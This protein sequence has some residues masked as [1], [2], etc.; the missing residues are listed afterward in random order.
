MDGFFGKRDGQAKLP[1]DGEY[2]QGSDAPLT[3]NYEETLKTINT[4]ESRAVSSCLLCGA[5]G[6]LLYGD[7][8]DYLFGAPGLWNLRKCSDPECGLIWIDPM[9]TEKDIGKAY[10]TYYTHSF[11]EANEY[12][13]APDLTR[14]IL[15]RAN[16][17]FLYLTGVRMEMS[18]LNYMYLG[19]LKPG[20]LLDVGCGGGLLLDRMRSIGWKVMG[21][22][23]DP[24]AANEAKNNFGL[25]VHVGSL[26]EAGY[27]DGIFDAVTMSHVIEH[28]HDPV[29]LLRECRRVLKPGGILVVVT[30]NIKSYLH[31]RFKKSWRG[32]EPPRHLHLFSRATMLVVAERAGLSSPKVWTTEANVEGIAHGSLNIQSGVANNMVEK[33]SFKQ[34]VR[35]KSLLMSAT[36]YK[37]MNPDSGEEV[38]LKVVK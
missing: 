37:K 11:N 2:D 14:K 38:V 9:P 13:G 26:D 27:P 19:N 24:L 29:A 22:E 31:E 7:L 28:V 16:N 33:T 21:V 36:L 1:H 17:L 10:S 34:K 12:A 20:L 4:I 8:S 18:K 25:Q 23:V 5:K 3:N 32:L 30:P 6:N 35:I 15:H